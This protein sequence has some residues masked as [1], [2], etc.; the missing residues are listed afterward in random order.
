MSPVFSRTRVLVIGT[1]D[2]LH[3]AVPSRSCVLSSV[4]PSP[5]MILSAPALVSLLL[6]GQSS[7]SLVPNE[8]STSTSPSSAKS[9][10]STFELPLRPPFPIYFSTP[11]TGTWLWLFT[12]MRELRAFCG[13]G[14]PCAVSPLCVSRE[15]EQDL[16]FLE[17]FVCVSLSLILVSC[18]ELGLS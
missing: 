4:S 2:S 5:T 17:G 9:Q 6:R 11:V 1:S 15:K 3:R 8:D 14:V 7:T 10:R 13:V 12:R 18:F 16:Y